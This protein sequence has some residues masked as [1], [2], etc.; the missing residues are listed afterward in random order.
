MQG[1]ESEFVGVG[2]FP[3]LKTKTKSNAEVPSIEK[4]NETR[5]LKFIWL[6]LQTKSQLLKFPRLKL[7]NAQFVFSCRSFQAFQDFQEFPNSH[8][9][10]IQAISFHVFGKHWS[11]IQDFQ[12]PLNGSSGF[13]GAVFSNNFKMLEFRAFEL[14]T[15]YILKNGSFFLELF[16]IN[17][18]SKITNNWFWE[19]WTR[20]KIRK[21]WKWWV[22]G[23]SPSEIYT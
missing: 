9:Q 20:Q 3:W 6:K 14:P 1:W 8:I 7:P 10:D 5:T 18:V 13:A 22:F 19:S 16:V 12:K 11:H 4:R 17:C 21:S 2:G 15:Y 23:F